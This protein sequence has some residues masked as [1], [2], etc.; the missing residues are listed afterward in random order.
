MKRSTVDDPFRKQ[1][2]PAPPPRPSTGTGNGER[3]KA[4]PNRG[5]IGCS[6]SDKLKTRRKSYLCEILLPVR[7]YTNYYIHIEEKV[8]EKVIESYYVPVSSTVACTVAG[9]FDSR[10]LRP[11]NICIGVYS[12]SKIF[13]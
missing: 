8:V 5:R 11:G 1:I 2:R 10:R 3:V 4:H 6:G 13:Q 7:Y 9:S 12:K